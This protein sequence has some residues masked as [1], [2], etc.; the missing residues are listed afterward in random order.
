[1]S[2]FLLF[3][4]IAMT[5]AGLIRYRNGPILNDK[6]LRI[7]YYD[8]SAVD[9]PNMQWINIEEKNKVF[10]DHC[11]FVFLFVIGYVY[12]FDIYCRYEKECC[13]LLWTLKQLV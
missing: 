10:S 11:V 9:E 7:M 2:S 13:T 6:P 12:T 1:M 5:I 3:N 4:I 8:P